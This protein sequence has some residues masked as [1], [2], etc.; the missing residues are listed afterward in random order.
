MTC[1]EKQNRHYLHVAE[2]FCLSNNGE[3]ESVGM[4][5]KLIRVKQIARIAK[6]I[7]YKKYIL[8]K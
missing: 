5:K 4:S 1:D 7:K 8:V 3:D 2:L 6:Y